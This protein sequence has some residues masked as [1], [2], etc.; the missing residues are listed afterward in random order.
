RLRAEKE[1]LGFYLNGHPISRYETELH[2]ITTCSLNSLS[3]GI[4]RV[5][6]Y[7]ESI[8]TRSG[9]RGRMAELR[10]DDRTGRAHVNLYSDVYEQYRSML[11]KDKLVVII[12]EVV[13]DEFYASGFSIKAD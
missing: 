4:A 5:A 1:T 8:R 7:I 13:S 6:G 3:P 2:A 9:Q 12:G 10:I 11:H